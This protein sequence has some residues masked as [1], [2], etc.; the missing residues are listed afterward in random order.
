MI[1]KHEQA[2]NSDLYS[3]NLIH[4]EHAFSKIVYDGY[5]VEQSADMDIIV[6]MNPPRFMPE[7]PDVLYMII[8][9][10]ERGFRFIY[11]Y[12]GEF[13]WHDMEYDKIHHIDYARFDQQGKSFYFTNGAEMKYEDLRGGI[14]MELGG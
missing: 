10:A 5:F 2:K 1:Y 7:V 13:Y 9:C 11:N 3:L 14:K 6:P 4:L 12:K 8:Y